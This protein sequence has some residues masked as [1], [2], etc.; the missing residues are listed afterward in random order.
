MEAEAREKIA[1]AAVL[2]NREQY[3]DAEQMVEGVDLPVIKPSL[4]AGNVFLD[5]ADWN[6][7]KG[8]WPEGAGHMLKFARA[9]QVDKSDL[10][11]EA[12]RGLLCVAPTLVAAG[13]ID[14][15]H[16]FVWETIDHFG[17]TQNPIAAEQVVKICALLPCDE[18]LLDA[19]EPLG[20]ILRQ[21]VDNVRIWST[22]DAYL[23]AW[24]VWALALL[25]YRLGNYEDA[26]SWSRENL[27]SRDSTP[28]RAAMDH[29]ILAMSLYQAGSVEE[30]LDQLQSG[31]NM[32]ATGLPYGLSR[33]VE[34]GS[35]TEG[36]WW[37]WVAARILLLEAE[38]LMGNP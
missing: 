35:N 21:S 11:D 14:G 38:S 27:M 36:F 31:K 9:V 5:L 33:V 34:V 32:I 7:E 12:T 24:R 2:L 20:D 23:H 16:R 15:Y 8:L 25:E 6:L 28:S 37:D 1:M 10:T 19:L 4:E 29:I 13:D 17:Q 22:W 26:A 3:E 30:S 18:S